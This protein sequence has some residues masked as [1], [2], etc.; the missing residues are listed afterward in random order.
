VHVNKPSANQFLISEQKQWLNYATNE[1]LKL[2]K[3]LLISFAGISSTTAS[4]FDRN[5]DLKIRA[6]EQQTTPGQ[7]TVRGRRLL[8]T[9]DFLIEISFK[10]EINY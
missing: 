5:L 2:C 9:S 8:L 7:Q 1:V 3:F 10:F 4:K 6:G